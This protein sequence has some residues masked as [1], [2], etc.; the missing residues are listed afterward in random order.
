MSISNNGFKC[1]KK[2]YPNCCWLHKRKYIININKHNTL[3]NNKNTYISNTNDN[4]KK[5]ISSNT[6]KKYNTSYTIKSNKY[7]PIHQSINRT[8]LNRHHP[9]HQSI[10]RT[11]SNGYHL[12]NIDDNNTT[13]KTIEN[14]DTINKT[15]ENKDTINKTTKN[16]DTINKTI[17]NKD[18][19]NKTIDDKD[20]TNKTTDDKDTTNKTTDDNI[21]DISDTDTDDVSMNNIKELEAIRN[22][23]H[24]SISVS[25]DSSETLALMNIPKN[26]PSYIRK[27]NNKYI[28][29][30]NKTKIN[31]KVW[32]LKDYKI[33]NPLGRGGFATVFECIDPDGKKYALKK[34]TAKNNRGIP[35]LMEA[36]IMNTYKHPY[37][38]NAEYIGSKEDGLYIIMDIAIQDLLHWRAN[39]HPTRQILRI[40]FHQ[41]SQGLAF[42]HSENIIHGDVK[43]SNILLYSLNPVC[44][45]LSDFNLSSNK[46][47]ESDLKVCTATHRPYEVWRGD[48]WTTKIDIWSFG[49]TIYELYHGRGLLSY[50]GKGLVNKKYMNAIIDAIKIIDPLYNVPTKF[51][52][53]YVQGKKISYNRKNNPCIKLM[54]MMLKLEPYDRP[55]I[56]DIL[57]NSYFHGLNTITGDFYNKNIFTRS[58]NIMNQ[59]VSQ[60]NILSITSDVMK[61]KLEWSTIM[62]TSKNNNLYKKITNAIMA[63][64]KNEM[65]F[66]TDDIEVLTLS[67]YICF[68]YFLHTNNRNNIIK[69]TSTWIARKIIRKASYDI[70][71]PIKNKESNMRTQILKTER[72]ICDIIGFRFHIY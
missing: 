50:Q 16:K 57:N 26:R 29:N 4:K 35:C 8:K 2:K 69:L 63:T 21:Y 12:T 25:S 33:G 52:I 24:I 59:N 54:N 27:Y 60:S 48:K 17:E 47:W 14:K 44:I 70:N 51:N 6:D 40:I 31:T 20:T 58:F 13:N 28:M 7:N 49:C 72:K 42:L 71:V 9:I 22:I 23:N 15:I 37:I 61:N 34:I 1:N 67:T 41:L 39:N 62:L 53:S 66:Y 10:N 43:A 45:K 38:A 56:S 32:T 55:T 11:K 36:S 3:Y 65:S 5:Y 46:E 18:T 19:T 30:N 68:Q 64:I